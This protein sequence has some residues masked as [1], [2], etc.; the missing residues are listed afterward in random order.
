MAYLSSDKYSGG[1][2]NPARAHPDYVIP[3]AVATSKVCLF[4]P[5]ALEKDIFRHQAF[6]SIGVVTEDTHLIDPKQTY[7][8]QCVKET[9]AVLCNVEVDRTFGYLTTA[10]KRFTGELFGRFASWDSKI[11]SFYTREG[12]ISFSTMV[13]SIKGK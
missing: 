13:S 12:D 4:N 9:M 2:A 6:Q 11:F 1:I 5:E 8:G 7:S 3:H 10:L